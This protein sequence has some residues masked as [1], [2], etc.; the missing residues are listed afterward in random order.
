MDIDILLFLQEL[1]ESAAPWVTDVLAFLSDA[2]TSMLPVI[3]CA[4]IYWCINKKA[5]AKMLMIFNCGNVVNELTKDIACVYRPWIKDSRVQVASQAASTATGYSFP[6]GHTTAATSFFCGAA[7]WLQEK[8]R[9]VWIPGILIPLFVAFTRLWLCAHTPQ[10][11]LVGFLLTLLVVFLVGPL[12]DWAEKK[13]NRDLKVMAAG[14][15]ISAAV[16][17]FVSL[18]SYPMDYTADGTLL[19]DPADMLPDCFHKVGG[20]VGFL[21]GWVL[22]KRCVRF[23]VTGTFLQRALRLVVG[24]VLMLVAY[25]LGSHGVTPLLGVYVGKFTSLFLVMFVIAGG[26]PLLLKLLHGKRAQK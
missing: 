5:G 10:D 21:C 7:Q 2:L 11:V 20:F 25:L 15:V 13:E 1:R 24:V 8:H 12:M 3:L 23:E 6:S 18:K 16:L 19:V 9:W 26:Y 17:L 14:L 4:M 22:E